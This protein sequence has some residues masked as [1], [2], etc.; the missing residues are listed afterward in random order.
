MRKYADIYDSAAYAIAGCG[1]KVLSRPKYAQEIKATEIVVLN[2]G[3]V[4]V[5]YLNSKD[6]IVAE[7]CGIREWYP[8]V[9]S[10]IEYKKRD[11]KYGDH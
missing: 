8:V 10:L 3:C 7:S 11:E 1:F 9:G 2:G 5:T 4:C 6:E